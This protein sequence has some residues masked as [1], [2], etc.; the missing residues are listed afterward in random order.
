MNGENTQRNSIYQKK[1]PAIIE[2]PE[3]K[4]FTIEGSGNPNSEPFKKNIEILYSLSYAVKMMPKKGMTPEGYVKWT[5]C[6]RH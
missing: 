5:L 6:Q 3:M 4:F 1:Q 2:V